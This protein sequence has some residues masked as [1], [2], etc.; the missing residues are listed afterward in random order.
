MTF[1]FLDQNETIIGTLNESEVCRVDECNFTAEFAFVE[2]PDFSMD[3]AVSVGFEDIDGNLVFYEIGIV[4]RDSDN[5]LLV[6]FDAEHAAM[7]ELLQQVVEGKAVTGAMAGFA[8]ARILEGSRW[9]V[10]SAE[11]TPQMST[12]FYFQNRW[13]CLGIIAKQTDCA[14]YFTWTVSGNAITGR[15]VIVKARAGASRG[16]RFE[17]T[18][19]MANIHV[20]IDRTQLYTR[21][22]GRGKGEEVGTNSEGDATYGRRI[23]FGEVVWDT[24]DGDPIDKP[25]NQLYIE[26]PAATAMFGR[27]PTGA[28]LPREGI[29]VFSDCE[30]PEELIELTWEKYQT[31][32]YPIL[33]IT[34]KVFDLERIWGYSHE[35]IR[36]GDDVL[37]ICDEWDA[38][39]TDRI[40]GLIRDYN[41]PENTEITIGAEGKTIASLTASLS[42]TIEKVKEKAEIGA[43]MAAANPSLLQ[44][45]ID[46]M[47]TVI[48]SSG[49]NMTTDATDGSLV[50]TAADGNSAVKITGN[51]ILISNQRVAGAWVWK[52][53]INGNGIATGELTAGTINATLIKILGTE[54]FYWDASNIFII[55][56]S[57]SN[58]QI[59]IGKYDGTHYGIAYTTNGGQT[60]QNAIGFDGVHFSTS[61]VVS[62]VLGSQQYIADMESKAD[63][64]DLEALEETA[65]ISVKNQFYLS[66]SATELSGDTWHDT[67]PVWQDG[68]YMW[69]Q[70]VV[71]YADDTTNTPVPI[72]IAGASGQSG[73]DGVGVDNVV[74]QYYKS[75]SATSLVG[76][77]WV[78][79]PPTWEVGCYIWTR[80]LVYYT[81]DLENPQISDPICTTG[82]P[83][84]NGSNGTNGTNGVSSY[85]YIR[86][87]PYSD[88]SDFTQNPNND[89]LYIG[90]AVTSSSTAPSSASAYTWSRYVGRDGQNGSNGTN[91]T[92]GVSSYTYIRYSA[93]ASGNPMTSSPQSD[94]KYIGICV[95]T[96]STAPTSYNSYTWSKYAGDDGTD[97]RDGTS[98][99]ILGS[100]DTVADLETAHPTGTAGDAYIID[101]D[102]YVWST[103]SGG[104]GAWQNV[105]Q[106]QGPAG[107][108]GTSQYTHIR[109]SASA[110]GSNMVSV[111]TSSTLYIGIAVTS[112]NSAPSTAS[113]YTWSRYVGE[114][115]QGGRDAYMYVR[116]SANASGADMTTT[117]TS[118]TKY[119]GFC[120]TTSSTAPSTA[121]L[122]TWSRYVGENGNSVSSVTPYYAK[123]SSATVKPSNPSTTN[124]HVVAPTIGYG[125]YLWCSYYIVM[126]NGDTSF[127]EPFMLNGADQVTQ[128][129]A[130]PENPATGMLWLDI[131]AEPMTLKRWDGSAWDEISDYTGQIE[132]INEYVDQITTRIEEERDSIQLF[133]QQ[134]TVAQSDYDIFSQTI[135]NILKMDPD[136]T[137]MIFQ[138]ITDQ[139]NQL[140]ATQASNHAEILKYIRFENGCII[141]GEQGNETELRLTNNVLGFWQNGQ[142]IAYFN[143][144]RL[145]VDKLEALT[146][147]K[148]GNYSFQPNTTGGMSLKY[149]G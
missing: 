145:Y 18:R 50:F 71:Y 35:A 40:V 91:G 16:K 13:D 4:K 45:V 12:T 97:G 115:G 116:Y 147:L 63:A 101:G 30:D 135:S 143:S 79:N 140:D 98:V 42:A 6:S 122:Y 73:E 123:G 46:T 106:I 38:T 112:S 32:R 125:E 114:D 126:S 44:S 23:D 107:Q 51:G 33:T 129:S 53:A 5:P 11:S 133:V 69:M 110:D 77:S 131:S 58:Q 100:Y 99:T 80:Q 136:G 14:F 84:Q 132:T 102:L 62:A 138:A 67:A 28:K 111:P 57:N 64:D 17:L 56:P 15:H 78:D 92:N 2:T 19:D 87:S 1:F 10:S 21:L 49:T 70:T 47:A 144:G 105:G 52:T 27:G 41:Q 149:I 37:V 142:Q 85:T 139:I 118:S 137:T 82:A 65:I 20:D 29:V 81:D 55:N 90:L 141:L 8:A 7:S 83:G 148:L 9:D 25:E 96:L 130:A 89:S 94:S 75:T 68:K 66:N 104:T 119:I 108:D 39:Y 59:K 34:A 36:R 128:A 109:Y 103:T 54:Q 88:G 26:D 146:S 86:Y 127:T 31:V 95:T 60:W 93:N 48:M 124:W 117:P 74:L 134:N 121:A 120:S 76:G 3:D 61:A 43:D 22:Y 24:D 72:C 113:S